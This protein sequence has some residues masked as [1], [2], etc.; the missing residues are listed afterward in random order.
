MPNDRVISSGGAFGLPADKGVYT[1]FQST[2]SAQQRR[3]KDREGTVKR[4][5]LSIGA[6]QVQLP[7]V[8]G[9]KFGSQAE[10]F[11]SKREVLKISVE[12]S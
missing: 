10:I 9:R 1:C 12:P 3:K 11:I 4:P 7:V 6:Q 2:L 5:K 8:I